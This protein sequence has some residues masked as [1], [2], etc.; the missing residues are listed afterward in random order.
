MEAQTKN[1]KVTEYK[2]KVVSIT[3]A[4]KF[5]AIGP[6]TTT[7]T[8]K[9]SR[10]NT[11]TVAVTVV[12]VSSKGMTYIT[13]GKTEKVRFPKVTNSKADWWKSSA[14]A[15]ATADTAKKTG[16]VTGKSYGSSDI[17][18]QYKRFTF[19]TTA[20]VEDPVME[21]GGKAI[22]NKEKIEMKAGEMKQFKV[23]KIY[24]T[25]NYKSSKPASAFIDENGFV[26]ARKKGK[27]NISTK[28]NG[29]TYQIAIEV[30]E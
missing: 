13:K 14:E 22:K 27:A 23:N 17:S 28:I 11:V 2:N 19:S 3:P 25:L 4:G 9:D 26:Y 1:G 21:F 12:P 16:K 15:V 6:G 24:Q 18:C 5:T 29:K 20:Y 30:T 8:G 10:S 7:V